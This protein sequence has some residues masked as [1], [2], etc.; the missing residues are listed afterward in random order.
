MSSPVRRCF[1]KRFGGDGVDTTNRWITGEYV[2]G[3]EE[4]KDGRDRSLWPSRGFLRGRLYRIKAG[5]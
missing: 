1:G 3:S 4:V 2:G 5:S